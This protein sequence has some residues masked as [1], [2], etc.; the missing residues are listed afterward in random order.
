[1]CTCTNKYY[2][3]TVGDVEKGKG[4]A[5]GS[6]TSTGHPDLSLEAVRGSLV[7]PQLIRKARCLYNQYIL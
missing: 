1:M 2:L 4:C 7:V 5:A 3:L 6:S